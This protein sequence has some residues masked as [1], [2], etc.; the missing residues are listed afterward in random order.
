MLF[1]PQSGLAYC[2]MLNQHSVLHTYTHTQGAV[3]LCA[4]VD[5]STAYVC[6]RSASVCQRMGPLFSVATCG[7]CSLSLPHVASS[8]L[9][10]WPVQTNTVCC[11]YTRS[12]AAVCKFDCS[13][14]D[15]C[16]P[17]ASVCQRM[18]PLFP[19]ATCGCCLHSMPH[20]ASSERG[21]CWLPAHSLVG[22]SSNSF[23]D[24]A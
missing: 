10:C 11:T 7:C 14:A 15:V 4:K 24:T 1:S 9:G 5:C 20:V 21:C 13:I 18:G 12:C 19:V 6:V 17:S 2:G 8:Q 3:L 16:V 22:E 23:L